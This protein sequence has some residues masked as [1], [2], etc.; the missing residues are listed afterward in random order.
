VLTSDNPR[1]EDAETI[2]RMIEKG[3]KEVNNA[4]YTVILD[5]YEGIRHA[6]HYAREGDIVVIAGKG[7]ENYQIIGDQVIP[8][9]DYQV[10]KEILQKEIVS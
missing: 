10:A 3:I 8:F 5:R 7:H 9:D 4:S 2:I 6:L 1:T